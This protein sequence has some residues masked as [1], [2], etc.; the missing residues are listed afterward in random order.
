MKKALEKLWYEYLCDKCSV[1]DTEE[2]RILI[3]K[4]AEMHKTVNESLTKEQNDVIE[5][6]IDSLFDVQSYFAKKSFLKGCEFTASFLL[7]TVF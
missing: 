4:A 5:K 3:K 6:Y 2:E 1:I 7:E